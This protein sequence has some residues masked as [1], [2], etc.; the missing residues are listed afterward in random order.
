MLDEYLENEGKLLDQQGSSFSQARPEPMAYELPTQ[1]S[2]YIWTL[3]NV[4]KKQPLSTPTSTL[5]SSFVPPSKRPKQIPPTT[6]KS[7][8]DRKLKT[9]SSKLKSKPA[10]LTGDL[11]PSSSS[12]AAS[13]ERPLGRPLTLATS[14]AQAVMPST[15]PSLTSQ[16]QDMSDADPPRTDTI[17]API[18]TPND[19][20][21]KKSKKLKSMSLHK[22]KPP[23]SEELVAGCQDMAPLESDSELHPAGNEATSQPRKHKA[24]VSITLLRQKDLE[25][26]AVWEGLPRT[27]VTEER[28]TVALTS[29]FT[30][31]VSPLQESRCS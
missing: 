10:S 5:I 27:Y 26:G 14:P 1:S 15:H 16:T 12:S 8:P 21:L 17:I 20:T 24:L 22:P 18:H 9:A 7:K 19:K 11:A 4:L 6:K 23:V 29:L 3:S 30:T 28:A 13:P 2:S 25:D 31:A